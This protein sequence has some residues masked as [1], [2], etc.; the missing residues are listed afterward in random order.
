MKFLSE[1]ARTRE[2]ANG[3]L[4]YYFAAVFLRAAP[5]FDDAIEQF[6]DAILAAGIEPP[7]NIVADG[8]IHRFSTN[9]SRKDD[10]GYYAYYPNNGMPAGFFGCW[11]SDIKV[12][13]SMTPEVSMTAEERAEYAQFCQN[14]QRERVVEQQRIWEEA[15]DR[16]K[17]L[18]AAAKDVP[19][20][21]SYLLKKG[22]K[23]HGLK[24]HDGH[25]LVPVRDKDR[26]LRS[27]QFIDTNGGKLFLEGG[28]AGGGD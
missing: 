4:V 16:A 20:D 21:H 10:A 18:W 28:Q 1:K 19:D 27:L 26:G 12:N 15:A 23:S 2:A 14:A 7:K 13:W 9:G 17:K 24:Y 6:R 11:R 3:S 25:L 8:R 5:M 22:V